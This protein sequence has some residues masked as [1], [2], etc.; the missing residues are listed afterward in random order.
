M[1]CFVYVCEIVMFGRKKQEGLSPKK[2]NEIL[3]A[4]KALGEGDSAALNALLDEFSDEDLL[5]LQK[6]LRDSMIK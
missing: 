3:A 6:K 4:L 5:H 2:Q 1:L